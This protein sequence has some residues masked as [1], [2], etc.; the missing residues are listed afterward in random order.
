MSKKLIES[1]NRRL[2]SAES[3]REPFLEEWR[4]L[5]YFV[6]GRRS[7]WLMEDKEKKRPQYN[8]KM[9]N[10]TPKVAVRTLAAGLR[11]GVTNPAEPWFRLA[12]PDPEMSE[13][14][15]VRRY[16]GDTERLMRHYFD[17]SNIYSVLQ[18]S[19]RQ[20]G[21]FGNG[22]VMMHDFPNNNAPFVAQH[23][24]AGSYSMLVD[25]FGNV[26]GFYRKFVMTAE[27][28]VTRYGENKA[29][30]KVREAYTKERYNEPFHVV[31]I[32][33]NDN[34]GESTTRGL[35]PIRSV[36]YEIAREGNEGFLSESGYNEWPVFVSR[37]EV[38]PG[39]TYSPHSPGLDALGD[40]KALQHDETRK[41]QLVDKGVD[42][43]VALPPSLQNQLGP[44]GGFQNGQ[45]I[46][47]D[48]SEKVRSIYDRGLLTVDV[49]GKEILVEEERINKA[50]Y[51]D[52][53]LMLTNTDRRQITAR[54]IE[55]RHEEKL[56]MLGPVLEN[57]Y[58]YSL[59][60]LIDRAYNILDRRGLLPEPPDELS[61]VDLKVE[62]ISVLAQAQKAQ[63]IASI[64]RMANF[65]S[66]L[67]P[68]W[69]EAR[70]KFNVYEAM[71]E[72]GDAVALPPRI[73]NSQEE[74]E[75]A[76]E[77]EQAQQQQLRAAEMAPGMAKAASDLS[78]AGIDPTAMAEA[79]ING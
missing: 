71:D 44:A 47:T 19:Y 49:V 66:A 23:F 33:E 41:G 56:L 8:R 29:C 79:A 54:E 30:R 67:V 48:E 37:W 4:M 31:H 10:S 34:I 74:A 42:P 1:Y 46:Y 15:P 14:P 9:V 53:F 27:Q 24:T 32:I 70:H 38:E 57:L 52:L 28:I 55:E 20:L 43:P 3:D 36:R 61:E 5:A 77:Q 17:R 13:F 40:A 78:N 45:Y 63:K 25:Q 51:T 12:T 69:A 58:Y 18:S 72:I 73:L 65:T 35:M 68:I 6:E 21:V 26:T 50:F 2:K 22:P 62:Y 76:A 16:L 60:P 75:E 59:N 39:D 11:A 64:E 7:G